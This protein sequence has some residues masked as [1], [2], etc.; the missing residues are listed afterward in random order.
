MAS[1]RSI[2]KVLDLL[3]RAPASRVES[4]RAGARAHAA[5]MRRIVGTE[6][7]VAVGIGEKITKGR[8]TGK[9]AL[10]FYV[11]RKVS[12][13]KLRADEV[14]P[15]TVPES[16][17]GPEAIPTDVVV[18][19]RLRPE[20]NAARG[21]VQ[22]GNSI[23]HVEITAGTLGAVVTKG[24][25][26]H[27]LSNSHVL[28]RGGLAKRGDAIIYPGDADGGAM[29]DDLVARLADF[30][31]FKTGG[32]FVNRVDCAIAKPTAAR[33]SALVPEIKGLGL[34]RGTIQPQRGMKVTKVGRTTGKT[35]GEVRDIHFRFVLDYEGVGEVG[36]VDQVLCTRYTAGGD[37]GS[38]VIDQATGRAVGLHFAGANGGSVFNPIDE[39]LKTLG[40]KLVTKTIGGAPQATGAKKRAAR[41]P[42]AKSAKK[43]AKK[44]AK[45]GAK[46]GAGKSA[47][48]AAGRAG[49]AKKR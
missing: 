9:L 20:V 29:P 34:P 33:L 38:L 1:E 28:A 27:V 11:E 5:S 12:L 31:K 2:E 18:L 6:N 41:E 37:S 17:G 43:G 3:T 10:T 4:L 47:K 40:V 45:K 13:R 46:K 15:P 23:G 44:A 19:G 24:D 39:V 30:V 35:K 7:V 25:A 14:V 21:P 48:R 22:P 26:L 36:F 8:R 49:G 32:E 42:A 16:L